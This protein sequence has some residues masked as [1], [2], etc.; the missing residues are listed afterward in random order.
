MSFFYWFSV[1]QFTECISVIHA[2]P[3]LII[4]RWAV[5]PTDVF[6]EKQRKQKGSC[7]LNPAGC[8]G[9]GRRFVFFPRPTMMHDAWWLLEKVCADIRVAVLSM[10]ATQISRLN[11]FKKK[12]KI[13]KICVQGNIHYA[14]GL[15]DVEDT[16]LISQ[17]YL[18]RLESKQSIQGFPGDLIVVGYFLDS[19]LCEVNFIWWKLVSTAPFLGRFC[20]NSYWI[21]ITNPSRVLDVNSNYIKFISRR[22]E[23]IK[24]PTA[25]RT[26][27]KPCT[28]GITLNIIQANDKICLGNPFK[29]KYMI[30]L[31]SSSIIKKIVKII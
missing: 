15:P 10:N 22:K 23:S 19:F 25:M 30:I 26:P 28:L 9:C 2:Q 21:P 18:D 17:T 31:K 16:F 13:R 11:V 4:R 5:P 29:L 8:C 27:G 20:G 7:R 12:M 3:Y 14:T 24:C 6:V 1:K